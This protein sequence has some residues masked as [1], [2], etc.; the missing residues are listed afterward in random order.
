MSEANMNSPY[1]RR[2]I[3]AHIRKLKRVHKLGQYSEVHKLACV[4]LKQK[5][6]QLSKCALYLK[7][8]QYWIKLSTKHPSETNHNFENSSLKS[9]IFCIKIKLFTIF[10]LRLRYF[11]IKIILMLNILPIL[12]LVCF[13]SKSIDKNRIFSEM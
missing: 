13:K 5:P 7:M 3:V 10:K 8:M 1:R 9:I 11:V 4:Y 6:N 2:L 12:G